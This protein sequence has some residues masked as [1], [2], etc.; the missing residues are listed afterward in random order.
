MR[1]YTKNQIILC[2]YYSNS[3]CKITY[4]FLNNKELFDF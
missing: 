3:G 4:F 2:Y 1:E